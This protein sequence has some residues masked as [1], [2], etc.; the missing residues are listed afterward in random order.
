M[1]NLN[2]L[3]ILTCCFVVSISMAAYY[4]KN[5]SDI[6]IVKSNLDNNDYLVR[7]VDKNSMYSGIEAANILA[8][9]RGKCIT[10]IKTLNENHKNTD[11]KEDAIFIKRLTN[12]FRPNSLSESSWFIKSARAIH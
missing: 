12:N 5:H 10:F 9:L 11:N 4:N 6:S 2:I 1:K 8:A 7:K 3:F